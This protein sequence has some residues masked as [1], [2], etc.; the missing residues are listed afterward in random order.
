MS[1]ARAIHYGFVR[2]SRSQSSIGRPLARALLV[3]FF[4]MSSEF[5]LQRNN[6]DA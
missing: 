2:Q 1:G 5:M 3:I 6:A 4:K